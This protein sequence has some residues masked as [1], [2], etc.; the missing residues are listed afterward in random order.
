MARQ[1]KDVDWVKLEQDYGAGVKSMRILESEYGIS[2]ARIGQ[3]AEENGWTRDRSARVKARTQAKLDRSLLDTKLDTEKH[4]SEMVL[5]EAAAENQ[6]DVILAHRQVINRVRS[7]A[8]ALL[9]RLSALN[10]YEFDHE[11]LGELL[12]NPD[13]K[14]RDRLNDIYR[15]VIE[16]P[17]QV[18]AIKKLA[19]TIK[20]LISLEREAFGIEGKGAVD[21]ITD[22]AT[23]ITVSFITA[24]PRPLIHQQ[25]H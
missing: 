23:N 10:V 15:R 14:N 1:K 18:D 24:Q 25:T 16:L 9:D 12:R 3:V 19:E 5:I 20:L 13:E 22:A 7:V 2:K 11:E 6:K 8:L 21:D 4:V 17:E